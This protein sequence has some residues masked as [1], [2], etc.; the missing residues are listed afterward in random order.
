MFEARLALVLLP[1]TPLLAVLL[2][3]PASA[4]VSDSLAAS[5]SLPVLF[6]VVLGYAAGA[7]LEWRALGSALSALTL[8]MFAAVVLT[9]YNQE[10]LATSNS[11][12]TL[13]LI[14]NVLL[15]LYTALELGAS[16]MRGASTAL[17]VVV[18]LLLAAAA[19]VYRTVLAQPNF[20]AEDEPTRGV[21]AIVGTAEF[22]AYLAGRVVAALASYPGGWHVSERVQLVA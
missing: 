21:L 17:V 3:F 13:C 15:F 14:H 1:V 4:V 6:G 18:A 5:D 10:L 7:L 2:V 22:A 12:N 20:D 11:C 9:A 19:V 16:R 8:P